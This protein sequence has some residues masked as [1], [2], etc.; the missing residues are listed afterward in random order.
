ME[1]P[2][3]AEW[4]Q[5][6]VK[7]AAV[8]ENFMTKKKTLWISFN[9][10][11]VCKSAF[12]FIVLGSI[13]GVIL[14][15][16]PAPPRYCGF[17]ICDDEQD[18]D[19]SPLVATCVRFFKY[20]MPEYAAE[21]VARLRAVVEARLQLRIGE[22]PPA[23]VAQ[24]AGLQD[25]YG[26]RVIPDSLCSL[27]N[28]APGALEHW[29]RA[30]GRSRESLVADVTLEVERRC[31]RSEE[32]PVT[33]RFWLFEGCAQTLFRWKLLDFPAAD[34][35]RTGVAQATGRESTGSGGT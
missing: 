8:C 19:N 35:L 34:V 30:A 17:P 4:L 32:R 10:L 13:C 2:Y 29:S 15:L 24:W 23:A 11:S 1:R 25:L 18:A 16:A 27:V 6:V 26:K 9:T 3:Y 20:L 33:T 31:L 14:G 21:F 12:N 28:G 22:P 7:Q 5:R